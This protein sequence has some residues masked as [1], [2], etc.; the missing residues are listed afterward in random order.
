MSAPVPKGGS[1]QILNWGRQRLGVSMQE[2][3]DF[4]MMVVP[5]EKKGEIMSAITS[6]RGLSARAT[7]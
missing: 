5:L 6:A 7:A 1:S 2:G 3:Q 4:V